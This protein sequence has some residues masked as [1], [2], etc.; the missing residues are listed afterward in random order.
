MALSLPE[1][2]KIIDG[3]GAWVGW[4]GWERN[5]TRI[6]LDGEFT[7]L[8]LEALLAVLKHEASSILAPSVHKK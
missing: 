1:A 3:I 6:T 5:Q 8:E 4:E 7:L 2:E